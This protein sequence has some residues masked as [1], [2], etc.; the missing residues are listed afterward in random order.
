MSMALRPPAGWKRARIPFLDR[1]LVAVHAHRVVSAAATDKMPGKR[2]GELQ[3]PNAPISIAREQMAHD[4][5][6]ASLSARSCCRYG[7]CS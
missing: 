3:P 5:M 7:L 4:R 6:F 1:L 2:A